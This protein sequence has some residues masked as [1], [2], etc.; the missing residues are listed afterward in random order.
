MVISAFGCR[1]AFSMA[2]RLFFLSS[3][4]PHVSLPFSG[5]PT[6]LPYSAPHSL[7]NLSI[8]LGELEEGPHES[9]TKYYVAFAVF[10]CF[11]VVSLV[12]LAFLY[13]T[14]Y[15]LH[16]FF[17]LSLSSFLYPIVLLSSPCFH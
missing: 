13:F 15:A 6:S 12:L 10:S 9:F 14:K 7:N 4:H 8:D 11:V 17:L 16:C 5:F 2:V 1:A 3:L